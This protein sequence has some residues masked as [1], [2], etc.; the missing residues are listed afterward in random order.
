MGYVPPLKSVINII[1]QPTCPSVNESKLCR[2]KTSTTNNRHVCIQDWPQAIRA[3]VESR[4]KGQKVS[5]RF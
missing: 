2:G 5:V 4:A 1:A 3:A